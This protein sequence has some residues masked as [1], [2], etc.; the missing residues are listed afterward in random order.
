MTG[1]ICAMEIELEKILLVTENK[2]ET[3]ISGKKYIKGSICG[4]NIVASVSGVGKVN[5]AICAQSMILRFSPNIII[6]SGV[7]GGLSDTIATT[8][9]VIADKVVQ[10]DMDMTPVGKNP[11]YIIGLDTVEIKCD[12]KITDALCRSV[13]KLGIHYET[14][15]IASG[16]QFIN[17]GEKVKYIKTVFNASATEMEGAAIGQVCAL[18]NVPFCV[19]RSISDKADSVSH[20]DN[21]TFEKIASENSAGAII[22]FIEDY[23]Q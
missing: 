13:K 18:N 19:L 15:T 12:K 6:N 22:G 5:A 7:A 10:H 17:G 1:I 3:V 4:K 9:I 8:D 11:G 2:E 21:Q 23:A 14:G 16:D 20:I